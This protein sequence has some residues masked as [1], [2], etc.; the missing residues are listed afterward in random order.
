VVFP[1]HIPFPKWLTRPTILAAQKARIL[2]IGT[3]GSTILSKK[4]SPGEELQPVPSE[5][6][7]VDRDQPELLNKRYTF[8]LGLSTAPVIG[9]FLLLATTSIP[10]SVVR[11]GIVGSQGVKPYDIMT[12]FIS[13]ASS[14]GSACLL[15]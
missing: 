6:E 5:P 15:S 7:P 13:L 1:I 14:Y 11:T 9:V 3:S 12:L 10:G 8:P 2:S 4:R